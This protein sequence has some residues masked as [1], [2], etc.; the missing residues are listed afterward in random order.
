MHVL[1]RGSIL[2]VAA[3]AFQTIAHLAN[4]FVFDDR[5]ASLDADVEA[6]VFTW[7]SSAAALAVALTALLYA[8]LPTR[9]RNAFLALGITAGFFSLDDAVQIHERIALR[10]GENLLGLPDYAAVRLWLVFY[11]PLLVL[12]AA[13]LWVLGREVWP[14]AGRA[15]H[16]GLGVLVASVPVE[17]AGLVTRPLEE[18][19][20]EAPDELRVAAEEGLELGGWLL[21]AA[22]MTAAVTVA[23]MTFREE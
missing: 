2:A 4:E 14:P 12:V 18:D 16:V 11:L 17:I 1:R 7:T 5:V 10:V 21:A 20:T 13:L 6:G 15:V 8:M 22:G 23:L 3:V 9:R 19:G